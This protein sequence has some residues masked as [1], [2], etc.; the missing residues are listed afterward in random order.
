[1][2]QRFSKLFPGKIPFGSPQSY[3]LYVEKGRGEIM[4]M[5]LTI[6]QLDFIHHQI[7]KTIPGICQTNN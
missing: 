2:S 6:L 7:L 4:K 3:H 5:S 1:M